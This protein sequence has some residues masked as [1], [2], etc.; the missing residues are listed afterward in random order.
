MAYYDEN[1]NE[2]EG[3]LSQE[4]VD[5]KLEDSKEAIKAEHAKEKQEGIDKQVELTK[6]RDD[7]KTALEAAEKG[8][9]G[10]K[11]GDTGDKSGDKDEN[12]A[13]LRKKLDDTTTALE[14]QKTTND[15]RWSKVTTETLEQTIKSVAG[16]DADLA[17]KVK[18]HY[19]TTLS[20]VKAE[21]PTEVK[22]KV[23]NALRLA[24]KTPAV[25]NP[26]DVAL[27]G[28]GSPGYQKPV[29]GDEK[30]YTPQD[31]QFGAKIGVTDADYKK[32]GNDPR[33][34]KKQ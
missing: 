19:E 7:A 23:A 13:A 4:E 34:D 26:L 25:V 27:G 14:T 30:E 3:V 17:E 2:V 16:E 11:G 10:D 5:K 9:G 20:G 33:L 1:G 31:K 22:E 15:E 21:T 28:Q 6:E 29:T 18:H 32:Y 12:M 24:G 8:E